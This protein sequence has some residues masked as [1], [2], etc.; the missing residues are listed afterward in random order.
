MFS[1]LLAVLF[2]ALV[3][4]SVVLQKTYS[5][6]PAKELKRR[7]EGGGPL[8]AR[9]WQAVAYG[10]SLRA[11]LWLVVVFSATLCFVLLSRVAPPFLGFVAVALL[12]YVVFSWLPA[13]ET[14]DVVARLSYAVTP[15][16]VWVLGYL[17]PV[18]LRVYRLVH[19]RNDGHVHTGVYVRDDLLELIERQ[20]SQADN[21]LSIEELNI[22]SSALKFG[23]R[24]VRELVIKRKK[25][26]TVDAAADISPVYL[27]ELHKSMHSR[28]P[29]YEGKPDNFVGVLYLGA[30]TSVGSGKGVRGKVKSHMSSGI[31]YLHEAD[32]LADALHAFYLTKRQLF[33]VINKFEEYVG[34]ITLEDILRALLGE[35]T[36]YDFDQHEV[37]SAVAA[38]H[39]KKP[40]PVDAVIDETVDAPEDTSTSVE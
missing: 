7:A 17:D 14:S 30:L 8:A 36:D 2:A 27:D 35:A 10:P 6:L 11:L 37:R 29:V 31:V 39:N 34:I 21:Q 12:L 33:I 9:F 19:R 18:L 4:I 23:E 26:I 24:K 38:K 28:F 22:A 15:A 5:A 16:V 1:Y 20:K 40:K 3:I 25:V 32:S 13:G